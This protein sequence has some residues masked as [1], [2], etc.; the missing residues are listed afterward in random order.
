MK[1]RICSAVL[2]R[3]VV[4]ALFL[5]RMLVVRIG[6]LLETEVGDINPSRNILKPSV[7]AT[8]L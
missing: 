8:L 6:S 3:S 5:D 1:W 7:V 4:A 2:N